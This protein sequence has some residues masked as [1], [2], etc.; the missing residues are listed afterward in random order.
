M[1]DPLIWIRAFHFAATVSAT[2]ALFFRLLVGEPALRIG[3]AGERLTAIMRARVGRIAWISLAVV[4]ATALPW[5]LVQAQRMSDLPLAAAIAQGVIWTVIAE[6]DFGAVWLARLVLAILLAGM[7][8]GWCQ[9]FGESWR[10]LVSGVLAACLSG[11][12]AFAGHAAAQ[13][14]IAGAIHLTADI[15][16]LIAA[17]AWVGALLPLAA[18]LGGAVWERDAESGAMA[19]AVTLRFSRLGIASVL[20]IVA[21]GVVNS[22]ME[23]NSVAALTATDYGRLLLV[24]IALFCG[25]LALAAIN[26]LWLTPR[27]TGDFDAATRANAVRR[28]RTNALIEAAIGAIILVIVAALSVLPPALVASAG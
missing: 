1:D 16:H 7:L 26:R 20:A 13:E 25:M 8:L 4:L 18:L 6:T 5:L 21:T 15:V 22:V 14:G 23:V 28:L 24:K 9:R 3:G 17:A 10:G 11:S 19:C 2:G 12:L 27:L